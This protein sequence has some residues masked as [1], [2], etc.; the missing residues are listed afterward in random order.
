MLEWVRLEASHPKVM[1]SDGSVAFLTVIVRAFT[2]KFI[3]D[4]YVNLYE[5]EL[6]SCYVR[7][8]DTH[9]MNLYVKFLKNTA[10]PKKIRVF[11]K[12]A[13]GQLMVP[14]NEKDTMRM[15]YSV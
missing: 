13:V 14:C 9:F 3:I 15:Q 8:D 5:R 10:K 6:P 11:Y 2:G 12:G 7:M 4:E 1:T